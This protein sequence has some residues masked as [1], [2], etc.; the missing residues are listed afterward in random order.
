MIVQR[1]FSSKAQKARRAKWEIQKQGRPSDMEIKNIKI[2]RG[3]I[4]DPDFPGWKK[5]NAPKKALTEKEAIDAAKKHNARRGSS[6]SDKV[7]KLAISEGHS[8]TY[9]VLDRNNEHI[10]NSSTRLVHKVGG[11]HFEESKPSTNLFKKEAKEDYNK[12]TK[13]GVDKK[14][15]EQKAKEE[16][17]RKIKEAEQKAK[18][19][20]KMAKKKAEEE[21]WEAVRKAEKAAKSKASIAKHEAKAAELRA[22]KEA[23]KMLK[24]GGKIALATGGVVAA[25]IGAKKLAD[26]KKAKKDDNPKK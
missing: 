10:S 3:D 25:G 24:K 5:K 12:K 2:G 21:K 14:A 4:E 26:K 19:A 11:K 13:P 18:E 22:K 9:D 15:A 23:G 20:E 1:L 7:R 8:K 16:A 6:V 17:D